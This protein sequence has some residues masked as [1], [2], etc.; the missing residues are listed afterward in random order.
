[1]SISED[2]AEKVYQTEYWNDGSGCKKVFAANTDDLQEAYIRGREAPP[3]D[4]EVEAVAKL[5]CWNSCEWDGV[6]SYAAKGEDDAWN[7][8]GEIPGFQEEYIRQAKEMLEIARKAV[9]E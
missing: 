1:M 3:S 9:S 4:V 7:Y 2:E 6:D 8:A 5:L